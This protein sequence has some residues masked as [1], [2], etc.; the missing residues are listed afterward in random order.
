MKLRPVGERVLVQQ[1]GEPVK[2]GWSTEKG[3]IVAIPVAAMCGR[4]RLAVGDV[5]LFTSYAGTQVCDG[6][7][8]LHLIAYN[9]IL[10]IVEGEEAGEPDEGQEGGG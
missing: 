7:E 10:A 3:R 1:I 2:E 6:K 5:V 8:G 9:D 4:E